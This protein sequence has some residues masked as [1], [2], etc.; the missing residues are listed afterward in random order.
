MLATLIALIAATLSP[1][2]TSDGFEKLDAG[3]FVRVA[4]EL[5]EWTAPDGAAEINRDHTHSGKSSLRLFGGDKRQV[6][7]RLRKRAKAGTVLRFWSERWT[8]RAPFHFAVE[9]RYGKEWRTLYEDTG[10]KIRVGG[11]LTRVDVPI[12]EACRQLRF[13]CTSPA[14]TGIMIDDVEFA[15]PQPMRIA[16][17]TVEQPT[18]PVL[19]GN[20][21]NPIARVRIDTVG[22]RKPL[23]LAALHLS[24]LSSGK[25][26]DLE[27]F[28]VYY[29]T[30]DRLDYRQP[31]QVFTTK[32]RFGKRGK[33]EASVV[34]EG[35]RVLAEGANYFWVSVSPSKAVD[36][37]GWVDVACTRVVFEDGTNMSP[38]VGDP[39][40]RQ[41]FGV[42]L[43][44]AGD[45]GAKAYRIPGIVTTN[46]GTVIAAYDVRYRGWGDLPGDIDVAISRS[47]DGGRS[48]E[49]MRIVMDMGRDERWNFDG[50]G[51][52]A[53]L[54]DRT[55]NTIWVAATWSHG[56]RS[57][58]GSGPG[59][60]PEETGQLL[61]VKSE[62]DGVTWSKPINITE[63]VKKRDWCFVL[64]SPGTGI[65]THDGTLVFP[66]QYQDTLENKRM[67]YATV[68]FSKDHGE[69]WS[70]GTGARSNTTECRVVEL[71]P[72]HWMLNM[73]D[74]RGGS[75]AVHTTRD[76]G[77]T[78][79]EH[80]SSRSALPEPVCN[81]GLVR[82]R[83]GE[84]P[85]TPWLLFS[86]P[87]VSKGPR[88]R[89]NLKLSKDGGQTWPEEFHLLIDQGASAGYSVVTM[90]DDQTIGVLY[91]CSRA[92]LAF[93]RIPLRD[94]TQ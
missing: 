42:A 35:K 78:W 67:P 79:Q 41:R 5:G 31:D 55:T 49:P 62:D 26:G 70:I 63:Q 92:H 24:L 28:E 22:A 32:Q 4:T 38:N 2:A 84:T 65:T 39:P 7:L 50:V 14:D 33:P 69:T 75:R 45:D 29:G 72:G 21:I 15:L 66:A 6:V 23:G 82:V 13:T 53:I 47:S 54:V 93:Q 43:R 40:G 16:G 20:S 11:F 87:A 8:R 83:D 61:L 19:V 88:E 73:R 34:V 91:E 3:R 48:W 27:R 44:N 59:F 37:D 30:S 9:G 86:N 36:L 12:A 58:R 60:S 71:E 17:I 10:D 57:W 51:D 74:N 25:L 94:L 1:P 80:P 90:I 81:A 68:M 46:E 77:K 52:P 56:N 89:T 76:A 64:A 18:L 85:A